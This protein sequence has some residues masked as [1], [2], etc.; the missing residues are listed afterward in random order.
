[1]VRAGHDQANLVA[2]KKYEVPNEKSFRDNL[3]PTMTIKNYEIQSSMPPVNTW[4]AYMVLEED[5]KGVNEHKSLIAGF[6]I[7]GKKH[8]IGKHFW[9]KK[10]TF[11][12]YAHHISMHQSLYGR[13]FS[14]NR[15]QTP[16]MSTTSSRPLTLSLRR[17]TSAPC[18]LP[19]EIAG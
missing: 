8:K 3:I 10:L 9:K 7:L 11:L 2:A 5:R 19:V 1:M 6:Y 15:A 17:A 14:A 13:V 16:D 4:R 12:T 18:I